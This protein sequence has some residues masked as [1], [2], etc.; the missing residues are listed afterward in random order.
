MHRGGTDRGRCYVNSQQIK[1]RFRSYIHLWIKNACR[2][3]QNADSLI[4][5]L[6]LVDQTVFI[7]NYSHDLQT[8]ILGVHIRRESIRQALLPTSRDLNAILGACQ[9]ADNCHGRVRS[10]RQRLQRCKST[11][12]QRDLDW[13]RLVISKVQDGLR[14]AAIDQLDPED[15][16]IWELDIHRDSEIRSRRRCLELFLRCSFLIFC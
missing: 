13:L 4:V 12:D 15:L 3:F 11:A 1:S 9:I 7:L 16:S 10:S 6:E 8:K 14:C 2:S 5:C